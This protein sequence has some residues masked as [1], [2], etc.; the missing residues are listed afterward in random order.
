MRTLAVALGMFGLLLLPA[1]AE[2]QSCPTGQVYCMA[3]WCCPTTADGGTNVCCNGNP[4]SMGCTTSGFCGTGSGDGGGG[5]DGGGSTGGDG[6]SPLCPTGDLYCNAGWCCPP[7]QNGRTDVC[8]NMNPMAN[9]C[10]SNGNCSTSM[11][12]SGS[13][14]GG[15]MPPAGCGTDKTFNA[16]S[17]AGSPSV[18]SKA[19][20]SIH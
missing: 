7:G 15:L 13:S 12:G 1:S 19:D 20:P 11:G 2:A 18:P 3:G 6:G 9:G 17:C 8:C 10:T 16:I 14:S 4:Q 5:G